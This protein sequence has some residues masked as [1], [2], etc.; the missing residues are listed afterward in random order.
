MA[1]HRITRGLDLP[2]AGAP[3]QQIGAARACTRVAL[4][5]A[6]YPGL[7]PAVRVQPG[8]RV[9][10]GDALFEDKRRP[11]VRFVSP[12]AGVVSAVHRGERRALQS[13]VVAVGEDDSA[14]GGQ[15]EL[16]AFS[17]RPVEA[18]EAAE[19]RALL[20]ESGDWTAFRTRP[21]GRVPAPE[22]RPAAIFVT[23]IDT[24]PHAPDVDTALAGR[25]DDF[26]AGVVAL[27]KLADGPVYVCRRPGS[28][29]PVP[30]GERIRG[31][32]FSGPHPAGTPGLH[33]H[34]LDPVDATRTAWHVG[35]Q[36]VAAI[37]RLLR[38]GRIDVE[39]VIALAGPG[40]LDPRLVGT[41]LG[42]ATD[43]LLRDGLA[44]G[45]QRVISGSVLD[46]RAAS[47][48]VLGY[49]GRHHQQVSALP[50]G[51]GREFLG[52][53]SPQPDKFSLLGVVLGAW[54]R[55]AHAMTT[56]TNGSPR[57]MVPIG[58]YERVMPMD[59]LPT[60]LL[61]ALITGDAERAQELGCLELDE[62][63]L[64]LCT[65]VCP[66]KYEYGP[67]LRSVLDRL[68]REAA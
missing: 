1:H 40:V 21:Y 51:R 7:Q 22:A 35:A 34:L 67:M 56:T 57:P 62:E 4:L 19:V 28:T 49:L 23:A 9:M 20:L 39:R 55:R 68:E 8:D 46:G 33:I 10:R 65:F 13:V 37:G 26:A 6:D 15:R 50:E 36:D 43:E 12:A 53:I 24:R 61:R 5:A 41:R 31:E 30:A 18:L 63:D 47:G 3:R 38:T 32:E 2:L 17:G 60:F 66:G 48:E 44:P 54:R 45:E 25:G 42:A 59:L 14:P 27:S 29:L 64:A 16:A 11:G 58:T 52:W